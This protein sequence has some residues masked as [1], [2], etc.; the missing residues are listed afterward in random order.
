M[1]SHKHTSHSAAQARRAQAHSASLAAILH[2]TAVQAGLHAGSACTFIP[3]ATSVV[4]LGGTQV[5]TA[6]GLG[7]ALP[8]RPRL[9]TLPTWMP[10]V[11]HR[12]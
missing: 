9:V 11:T 8:T 7:W 1:V 3:L 4:T 5:G 12:P 6:A 2:T 10:L